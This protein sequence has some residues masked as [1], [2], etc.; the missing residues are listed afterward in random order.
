[1]CERRPSDEN[2]LNRRMN[3]T[4]ESSTSQTPA[5]AQSRARAKLQI[6]FTV[7]A[8]KRFLCVE[9]LRLVPRGSLG[10]FALL[11]EFGG[12]ARLDFPFKGKAACS[13][14]QE[15]E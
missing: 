9:W 15:L 7:T 8:Q 10:P 4:K 3:Q 5:I 2:A 1:M 13:R 11:Q 6:S 14:Y 12:I